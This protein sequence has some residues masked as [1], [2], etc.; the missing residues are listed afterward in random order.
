M[1]VMGLTSMQPPI[2]WGFNSELFFAAQF[3][4]FG[5]W[6]CHGSKAK[7]YGGGR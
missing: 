2:H 3:L 6:S 5:G 1:D 7:A 4:L